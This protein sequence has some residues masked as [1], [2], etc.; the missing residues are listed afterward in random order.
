M[1]TSPMTTIKHVS[2]TNQIG[3][4]CKVTKKEYYKIQKLTKTSLMITM[5][6]V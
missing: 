3:H 6:H 1:R 4:A 2:P 5:K